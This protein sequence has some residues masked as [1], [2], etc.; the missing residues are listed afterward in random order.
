MAQLAKL[1]PSGRPAEDGLYDPEL[2]KDACGAG[3]V[4]DL[5]GAQ[6]R[7]T[8]VDALTMLERMD[9][10]GA[11]GCE[12]NT[13]DGAGILM[14][15]P[16]Q[17]MKR[18]S[19]ECKFDLP[20]E[21]MYGLG[22]IFLPVTKETHDET[23]EIVN[24]TAKDLGL[25]VL[26][27][28]AVPTSNTKIGYTAKLKEPSS[29][30]V[31]IAPDGSLTTPQLDIK[32]FAMLKIATN[33][34]NKAID[35]H[36]EKFDIIP[37]FCSLSTRTVVYK[38]QLLATQISDYFID[39]KAD[40]MKSNMCMVHS[41]FSTNT[42]PSWDRAQPLRN[43]AHNGE[44]NTCR[45]NK[46]WMRTREGLLH[47]QALGLTPEQLAEIFPIIEPDRSDSGVM[48]N[49]LSLL[50]ACGREIPEAM[51]ML[52]PEAWQS[53]PTMADNRRAFYEYHSALM[54]PW[55]GPA[56]VMFTDG[57]Y[58]GGALDRN[59]L[60]PGRFV[61][62]NDNHVY[63]SSEAGTVDVA[64]ER[65]RRK[66]RLSPGN[67]FLLDLVEGTI[68]EDVVIK[69][70][71]CNK[72]PYR[73]WLD[74]QVVDL[75]RLI[76]AKSETAMIPVGE[77]F[78]TVDSLIPVLSRFGWTLE[79]VELLLIPM[80]TNGM[81]ALGSMGNDSP[82]SV[83]AIKQHNICD[84]F[85]Q[86]FAQVTNP[87]LDS[88]RESCVMTLETLVGPEGDLTETT[89][90]QCHRLRLKSPILTLEEYQAIEAMD[91]DGWRSKVIDIT[92]SSSG[93]PSLKTV[94]ERII[95]ESKT[96]VEEGVT[97]VILSDEMTSESRIA[98]PA[99]MVIGAVH[100]ALVREKVRTRVA[101]ILNSGEA[102]EVHHMCVL[103]G[104]GCDAICPR[105]TFQLINVLPNLKIPDAAQKYI[106]AIHKGMFKI[107]AK[108]GIS[109]LQSY[110][111]AQIFE[112]I[113]LGE[114]VIDLCFAGTASRIGGQNLEMLM[115]RLLD[116]HR[117]A[118]AHLKAG[119]LVFANPGDYHFRSNEGS[120]KHLNDP[121]TIAK[122]QEAARTNSVAAY[123]DY[124]R[125]INELNAKITVRGQLRFKTGVR[126]RIPIEQVEP[127]SEIVKRF[128]T[129]AMSY[130]SISLESHSTLAIAMNRLG[131]KSNTGE[132]G[133]AASRLAPLEDGS[134][135]P[136]RSA[137]K[138]VASGR[139]GVTSVY[140]TN[141][142]EI[143]IKMAQ[144]AK[145]GEGGELPG[146]KV[147]GDIAKTRQATPG[148]GLISP[149][150]HHDIY[151][152]EDLKQLI[153]DLKNANPSA[154]VSVKLVSE[155]GVGVVAAG[156][157]KG[158]ADH[159]LIS[160]HDGG[161]GASR[162]SGI[163]HAGLPWELGLAETQQT[164]VMNNLR[165]RVVVQTDGQ[166]KTG[167]DVAIAALL[168]AEEFGFATAPLIAMGCIMMRKCHLNTCPV[169][170]ATQDP[171]LRKKFAGTPEH[172]QN[173]FFLLAEDLRQIMSELG[174]ASIKDMVGRVDV[175]E[176]DPDLC[177]KTGIDLS[178]MLKPATSFHANAS[179][180]SIE[181]QNHNLET[182]LD[183]QLIEQCRDALSLD[184]IPVSICVDVKNTD[185]SIG[186]TLSH[187]VT[188]VFGTSK[189]PHGTIH[190]EMNG[191]AG[192]SFG[193][194][195]CSGIEFELLGDTNDYFA[196]GLCGGI[197]SVK[198]PDGMNPNYKTNENIICG[199]VALYGATSGSAFIAGK[200]G[201]RF[202]V[203]NSGAKAV[204]EGIGDH[205][206]E[207]MTGG[208]A[209]I[210]GDFGRNF[211]AG[212]SGG[213]AYVYDPSKK[214]AKIYNPELIELMPVT[215][216]TDIAELKSMIQQHRKYT[217][218]KIAG[219][220]L[221]NWNSELGLFIKVIPT[222]YR[223]ALEKLAAASKV[224]DEG[225][226]TKKAKVVKP[227]TP[228]PAS[229]DDIEDIL[230]KSIA[231]PVV[232]P[233]PGKKRGFIEYSREALKYRPA[234]VRALDWKEIQEDHTPESEKVRTTQAARCMDCGVPFCHQ[235]ETGCPLGNRI[236]EWNEYV[237]KGD[238]KRALDAL[239]QTNNFPEFT[240]RVCPAP[241]EG[242]CVLGIIEKP[243]AIKSIECSIIDRGFENGWMVPKPPATRSG[244]TVAIVGGG[245]A[246]MA[247]ADQLNKAGHKVTVYERSD[248]IGGLMMYGVPNMKADKEHVVQ[249]R[250]DLMAQEGVI[251]V[252]N[253]SI[254]KD[255][256]LENLRKD[257]D[258]VLLTVGSTTARDLPIP[259]RN[260]SGVHF[261]MEYLTKNTKSLLDSKHSD[262]K[263][264]NVKD[265]KV[266][267]I[268]GGDTG[269]DC[270]G[271]SVR[272]GA[273]AVV[274]LEL[275]PKPPDER[276]PDN[277]WPQWPRVFRV[278]YGHQEVAHK[279]G[280]D[281]RMY[282]ILS[283][284]FIDDGKGNVKG[285][286]VVNV[287]WTKDENGRWKM[288]EIAGSEQT[289]EA[290]FVFLAM[291]FVG[292]EA[293]VFE[294]TP[295]EL[296]KFK[297]IQADVNTGPKP[298]A[299][300]QVG[301]FAAGDCRRGQSL[302]VWAIAEG[303]NASAAICEY[304][305][306]K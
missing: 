93:T 254:G 275:L 194:F 227:I 54:E 208:R 108:M 220:M 28:R 12:E 121:S 182:V 27:W 303:R 248:R 238:Y 298:Y 52:I 49:V 91:L 46:S 106:K 190:I 123:A 228:P 195:L 268:G 202:C 68:T 204:V 176:A 72:R 271:T 33:R 66:G 147:I 94:I 127:A 234:P 1:A 157:V 99:A 11:C 158:K 119:P 259:G 145:P 50:L 184:P 236:P 301:V 63:M 166:L 25:K 299:T 43:I 39:L 165:G 213:I 263:Y 251:F 207:Y 185:R 245:P 130:G 285:I 231:K 160:G 31:F 146:H 209:V 15:I 252:T 7:A 97:A 140:L 181:K 161:T 98:V 162:W 41:R 288:S 189:M 112:A 180:I 107:M 73:Q 289:I 36:A 87:P 221:S 258:A 37:H 71:I 137:I 57:N 266:V 240:G 199:N 219:H 222:D 277:P 138:Q 26:G 188:K 186:T 23:K 150:P 261:A 128:C 76:K 153:Y 58:V 45:G 293:K 193:A 141:A 291:G 155:V 82:L 16:Q 211:G 197:L 156:V 83:L 154:R 302:V 44:I 38:G 290:D 246:G 111:G 149:P 133:E 74:R 287:D 270:I 126:E 85:K 30:Q 75:D 14:R 295:L 296:N 286:N 143:Q 214:L 80:C 135:N 216:V 230:P 283:K 280:D 232:V 242:S 116:G 48:D 2:E 159:V 81:E 281:P 172:V 267:V 239:L 20:K 183:V 175:L 198:P 117:A 262:G 29:Y 65:I 224:T 18:V 90:A 200:A 78:S 223:L 274:N 174:F 104:Y 305:D 306:S 59:G 250:V 203:R 105:T 279:F 102:R 235:K 42:F 170:I 294:G 253:T 264:I 67:L 278:D 273:S 218:S 96:A 244:K 205:G 13:G 79:T 272:L 206:C 241:C 95:A 129:G 22:F 139:F 136:Q 284:E 233:K 51:M 120:E 21:G 247:A 257:F 62:T 152:I 64:P 34:F 32:L 297:N 300:S 47:C 131:G 169:G 304:L 10:R 89:E 5:S 122:L 282:K 109:T 212:M 88:T 163:K 124:A 173:F 35:D 249:R 9:H 110:K 292:P 6:S 55:D 229:K 210:L 134:M 40:D 70:K 151:S 125:M 132:G 217:K 269:N 256:L 61:E 103:V 24:Q 148:V 53:H 177:K 215:D 8:V 17:F 56:L 168:G 171:E 167:R 92:F 187:E 201:E 3:F 60:R 19:V 255:I 114:D 86:L 191:S 243:V 77:E 69:D 113:G 101:L 192:Q 237:F 144:G 84:Y 226:K 179:I 100:H 4:A 265:K 196:K 118:L 115:T 225:P 142:D 260:L 178:K 164:L 276:A